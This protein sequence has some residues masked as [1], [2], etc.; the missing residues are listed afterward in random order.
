M[1]RFQPWDRLWFH[2]SDMHDSRSKHTNSFFKHLYCCGI[3]GVTKMRN[4]KQQYRLVH[5]SY[6][7]VAM[8]TQGSTPYGATNRYLADFTTNALGDKM[9]ICT[10]CH[11]NNNNP[12][13]APYVMYNS[14]TYMRS[15][16][17][18]NYL[19]VQMLSFLDIGTH[20]QSKDWGF[21]VGEIVDTSLLGNP[22]FGYGTGL[23]SLQSIE[24]FASS[25]SP[26]LA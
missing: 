18:T 11:S 10:Q 1:Q 17:T 3:C 12:P 25:L 20:I 26:L 13:N 14:P 7:D 22:L 8:P 16:I 19:H 24:H 9:I 2:R 5:D 6:N 4:R 21:S 15:I 23:D